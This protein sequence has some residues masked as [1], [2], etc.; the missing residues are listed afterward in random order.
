MIIAH[1]EQKLVCMR[2]RMRDHARPI[3]AKA[4]AVSAEAPKQP[5]QKPAVQ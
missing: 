3:K 5:A 2:K 4:P 1:E